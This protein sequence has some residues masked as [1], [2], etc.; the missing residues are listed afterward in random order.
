MLSCLGIETP[1]GGMLKGFEKKNK[2]T[3]QQKKRVWGTVTR[4]VSKE[5]RMGSMGADHGEPF[6]S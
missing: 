2:K 3:K 6:V 1:G 5:M 4:P